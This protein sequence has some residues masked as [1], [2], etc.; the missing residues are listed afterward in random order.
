MGGFSV[1]GKVC[2]ITGS[3]GGIGK[4]FA[5]QL[6]DMGAKVCISDVNE[7]LG[8]QTLQHFKEQFNDNDVTFYKLNVV[9]VEQ[10]QLAFNHCEEFFKEPVELLINNAGI[11]PNPNHDLNLDINIRG[12]MHGSVAFVNRYGKSKDGGR[13][14]RIVQISS[15]AGLLNGFRWDRS[16]YEVS[17]WGVVAYTRQFSESG[18]KT[19]PWLVEGVKSY[20]FCPLFVDT[21]ILDD[22]EFD[23]KRMEKRTGFRTLTPS[24]MGPVLATA[25]KEDDNGAVY[26]IFPDMPVLKVPNWNKELMA[27]MVG[28]GKLTALVNPQQRSLDAKTAVMT[29]VVAFLLFT[30]ILGLLA[31]RFIF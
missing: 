2:L 24:E 30:F 3:A 14:G 25:L 13:G 19:H 20:A 10:W 31:A 12:V 29:L 27:A 4:A 7:T 11:A 17:K 5:N 28:L 22:G 9:D 6:L 15:M 18:R 16:G 23:K 1:V 26:A 8:L 21:P